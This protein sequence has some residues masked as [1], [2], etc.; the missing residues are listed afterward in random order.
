MFK[1]IFLMRDKTFDDFTWHSSVGID[2]TLCARGTIARIANT[3]R[4]RKAFT[5]VADGKNFL[6]HKTT[7]ALWRVSEDKKTIEPVFPSDVLSED[8]LK[9]IME[10]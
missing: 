10:D 6:V 5:L 9:E 1:E 4:V 3:D 7:R 8:E 2:S